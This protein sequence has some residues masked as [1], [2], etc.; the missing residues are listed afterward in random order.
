MR[1]K[2]GEIRLCVEF[3]N[4]NRCSWKDNYLESFMDKDLFFYCIRTLKNKICL[5]V[6]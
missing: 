4:L 2:N 3:R 6:D 5:L 1:K